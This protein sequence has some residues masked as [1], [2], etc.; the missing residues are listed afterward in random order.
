MIELEGELEPTDERLPADIDPD[1]IDTRREERLRGGT[2]PLRVH[3]PEGRRR[4]NAV[5]DGGGAP[6]GPCSVLNIGGTVDDI[7]NHLAAVVANQ[8]LQDVRI[9]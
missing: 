5:P 8:A 6:A 4:V 3:V 9:R 7:K 1:C 2:G